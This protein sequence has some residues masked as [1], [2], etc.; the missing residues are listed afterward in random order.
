MVEGQEIG[1]AKCPFRVYDGLTCSLIHWQLSSCYFYSF[2]KIYIYFWLHCVLVAHTSSSLVAVCR[3]LTAVASLV[4]ERRLQVHGL[5]Q[6]WLPGSRAQ[7][8]QLWCVGLVAPQHVGSSRT[9]DRTRVFCIG[10]RILNHWTTREAPA[11]TL[12]FN[13]MWMFHLC[14]SAGLGWFLGKDEESWRPPHHL[15]I[16]STRLGHWLLPVGADGLDGVFPAQLK[17]A[18]EVL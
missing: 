4:A 18:Q 5:Q 3:L 14:P 1:I 16:I 6:L 17:K 11:F 10:R 13:T 9:R 2:L 15:C 8:Q 12:V 7:A